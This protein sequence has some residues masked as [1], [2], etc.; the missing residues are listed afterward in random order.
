M[1]RK[2]LLV[3]S[4]LFDPAQMYDYVASEVLSYCSV[5]SPA[6]CTISTLAIK[7]YKFYQTIEE[8]DCIAF[9]LSFGTK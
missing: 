7:M 3:E 1:K 6:T 9:S 2:D 4:V 8:N 5:R